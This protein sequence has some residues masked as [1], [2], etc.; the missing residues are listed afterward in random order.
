M[1]RT[2]QNHFI[3]IFQE[4]RQARFEILTSIEDTSV[5]SGFLTE[6]QKK[7]NLG[8]LVFYMTN[9]TTQTLQR[10]YPS[11]PPLDSTHSTRDLIF[12]GQVIRTGIPLLRHRESELDARKRVTL[13]IPIKGNNEVVGALEIQTSDGLPLSVDLCRSLELLVTDAAIALTNAYTLARFKSKVG[14]DELTGLH[15]QEHFLKLLDVEIKR[16][17][18][19]QRP[20]GV[21]FFQPDPLAASGSI[22]REKALQHVAGVLKKSVRATDVL[23]RFGDA[24]FA[25]ALVG[26]DM[27][28]SLLVAER[29]R[30]RIA[31]EPWG[32]LGEITVSV[33]ASAYPVHANEPAELIF[34]ARQASYL[35]THDGGNQVSII[36]SDSIGPKALKAFAS[37]LH[38]EDFQTGPQLAIEIVDYVGELANEPSLSPMLPQIIESLARAVDVKDRYPKN[39]YEE[40]AQYAEALGKACSLSEK[41]L[42]LLRMA[43]KLHDLGKIGIPEQILQ[44]KGPLDEDEWKILEQHPTLGA[45]ILQRVPSLA[46]LVPLIQCHHEWWNGSGYPAGLKETQIPIEARIVA[47]LDS[48]QAIISER[49]YQEA[50]PAS[51]ALDE[52]RNQAGTRF[53]PFL[54]EIFCSV[55]NLDKSS[56]QPYR[57]SQAIEAAN[58]ELGP[59]ILSV[60]EWGPVV[61]EN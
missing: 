43:T 52:L 59:T 55:L 25:V 3:N 41:Q 2:P 27:E 48:F 11:T 40:A 49:P 17:R 7:L 14:Y 33:G 20:L 57:I 26:T 23:A 37:I 13:T 54:I 51:Y 16:S 24:E 12:A 10:A 8:S 5:V 39:H 50:F 36:D 42:E 60:P 18:R 45:K 9:A 19:D 58:Q 1:T 46:E 6:V 56:Q 35:A 53:D 44:K 47:I 31:Q 22:W 61:S 4:L 32:Y 15:N 28:M 29:F 21:L 34:L 30:G 38:R